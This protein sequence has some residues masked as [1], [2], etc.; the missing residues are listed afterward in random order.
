[1][2]RRGLPEK[3]LHKKSPQIEH[4]TDLIP[5]QDGFFTY[6]Q[7]D[8][9]IVPENQVRKHFDA[10][11]LQELAQSIKING[12]I[13]PLTVREDQGMTY[14]ISGERRYRACVELG[15]Q[16]IPVIYTNKKPDIL[17][18]IENLQREDLTPFEEA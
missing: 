16:Y 5:I 4:P 14:L 1:M 17:S 15:I 18:L 3:V 9:I 2:K 11:R 6:M 8:K 7:I 12:I 10:G 13:N